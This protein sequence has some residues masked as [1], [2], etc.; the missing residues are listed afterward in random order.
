MLG[1]PH[2]SLINILEE[3]KTNSHANLLSP[4]EGENAGI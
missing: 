1:F 4:L 3:L 2:S